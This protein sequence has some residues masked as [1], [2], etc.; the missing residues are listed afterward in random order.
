MD[1]LYSVRLQGD[2]PVAL[3]RNG[4]VIMGHDV[5][6]DGEAWISAR[7]ESEEVSVAVAWFQ[8]KE[9]LHTTLSDVAAS[10]R[11]DIKAAKRNGATLDNISLNYNLRKSVIK[12]VLRA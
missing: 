11:W 1:Y 4:R 5:A 10:R 3:T 8:R 6:H 12:Q 2:A 9:R 7:P